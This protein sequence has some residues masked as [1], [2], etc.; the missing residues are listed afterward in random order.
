VDGEAREQ[1]EHRERA[2]GIYHELA[3]TANRLGSQ[4]VVA[5]HSEVVLNEAETDTVVA[6]V[7]KP[8]P[9]RQTKELRKALSLLGYE[10]FVQAE[11]AATALSAAGQQ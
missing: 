4:L 5:T 8:H 7:G 10:Q 6:F 2:G 1:E 9:V 11:I 3:A